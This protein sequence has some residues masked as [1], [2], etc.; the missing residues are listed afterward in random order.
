MK[1]I[2][3]CIFFMLFAFSYTCLAASEAEIFMS[4]LSHSNSVDRRKEIRE[5]VINRPDL[6][7]Q[8]LLFEH[9]QASWHH[10]GKWIAYNCFEVSSS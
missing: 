4:D 1:K 9:P 10:T 5:N 2:F 8:I 6:A 7:K 3:G